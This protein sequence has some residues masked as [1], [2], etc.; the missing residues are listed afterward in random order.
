MAGIYVHIPFCKQA[1]HYCNF[2]F[3]TSTKLKNGFLEA[4]LKETVIQK[5]FLADEVVETIYFGGGTPSLLLAQE[6]R[7]VLDS[8]YTNYL[9]APDAEISLEANPDDISPEKLTAWKDAG[10]NRLSIGVQSFF[11]TDLH[12]MNR[13]HN[14]AQAERSIEMAYEA[15]LENLSIDLIFGTPTLTDENWRLNVEKAIALQITHLSCYSLPVILYTA[16]IARSET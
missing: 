12:W 6:I 4:L 15:G 5:N 3:S 2:H 13:A 16:E 8:I 14:S 9:I 11:D 7:E 10:I 1:C